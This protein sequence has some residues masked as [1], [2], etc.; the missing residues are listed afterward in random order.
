MVLPHWKEAVLLPVQKFKDFPRPKL[1][2][3]NHYHQWVEACM[4][5]GQAEAGFD[6]SGP[7][8]ET[9]LLGTVALRL[10]GQ[11]LEWDA[12]N[13]TFTNAQEANAL[14]R[15]TYRD[16]WSVEGLSG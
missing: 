15:R 10:P 4:G 16:G 14:L 6:Y 9:V 11:T 12:A 5:E 3:V 8:T 13:M 1:K 2:S 7:L